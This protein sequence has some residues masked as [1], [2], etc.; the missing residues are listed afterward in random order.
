MAIKTREEILASLH[1]R[2]GDESGDDVLGIY[3]DI[4]DTFTDFENKTKDTT[5]WQQKYEQNDAEWREKYR[6]RFMAPKED[7]EEDELLKPH[8]NPAKRAKTFEELFKEE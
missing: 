4:S 8:Q 6:S 5:N 3:E 2:F 7:D 1:E